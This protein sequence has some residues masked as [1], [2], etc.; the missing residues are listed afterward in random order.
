MPIGSLMV[1]DGGRSSVLF[2]R[3][4]AVVDRCGYALLWGQHD[5]PLNRIRPRPLLVVEFHPKEAT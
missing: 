4:S 2:L 1:A 5:C 3:L